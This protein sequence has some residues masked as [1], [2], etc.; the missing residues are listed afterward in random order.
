MRSPPEPWQER[1]AGEESQTQREIPALWV[2][3]A[4][5]AM[6]PIDLQPLR[7]R[8]TSPIKV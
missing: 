3:A 4:A 7:G 5:L 8:G 6:Q 1:K 2:T